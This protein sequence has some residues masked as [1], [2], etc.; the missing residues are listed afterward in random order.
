M[1]NNMQEDDKLLFSIGWL[2][3]NLINVGDVFTYD[4][5]VWKVTLDFKYEW[6]I[7]ATDEGQAL[8]GVIDHL[9]EKDSLG[10]FIY[11]DAE[12]ETLTKEEQEACTVAGNHC[13]NLDCEVKCEVVYS[14]RS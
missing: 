12:F 14:V 7:C 2:K 9:E 5:P 8:D 11:T 1:F 13:Y 10:L 3:Q 6:F 4:Y